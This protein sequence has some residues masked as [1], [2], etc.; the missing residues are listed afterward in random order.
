MINLVFVLFAWK[1]KRKILWEKGKNKRYGCW[2]AL[3]QRKLDALLFCW[4]SSGWPAGWRERSK[5]AVGQWEQ[6]EAEQAACRMLALMVVSDGE[7]LIPLLHFCNDFVFSFSICW[8]SHPEGSERED[9]GRKSKGGMGEDEGQETF[10]QYLLNYVVNNLLSRKMSGK[11]LGGV[12]RSL[13]CLQGSPPPW[14]K[15]V[16]SFFMGVK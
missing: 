7:P 5:R 13:G 3:L 2:D 15:L 1:E 10:R 11:A 12:G 8:T 14:W 4:P 6:R 16:F 9:V